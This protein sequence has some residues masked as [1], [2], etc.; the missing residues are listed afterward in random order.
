M[1]PKLRQDAKTPQIAAEDGVGPGPVGEDLGGGNLDVQAP[2]TFESRTGSKKISGRFEEDLEDS[3]NTPSRLGGGLRK[4]APWYRRASLLGSQ[5]ALGRSW[6]GH[7]RSWA[8]LGGVLDV[9]LEPSWEST[10]HGGRDA[11]ATPK[12]NSDLLGIRKRIL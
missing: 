11:E 8:V 12:E 4:A 5:E 9:I 2:R 7:G 10:A 1:G 6:G 3:F